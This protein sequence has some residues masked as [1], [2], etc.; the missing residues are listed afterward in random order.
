MK[1]ATLLERLARAG[2]GDQHVHSNDA[3]RLRDSILAN[4]R[5]V[6]ATRQGHAPAQ[7]D[8]GTPSPSEL[9]KDYPASIPR[10]QRTLGSCIQRYEPRLTAVRVRHLAHDSAADSDALGLRF[11]ISAELADGS[12]TPLLFTT[13]VDAHGRVDLAP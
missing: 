8:L 2:G 4:L 9:I 13:Q 11:Q 3:T 7:P 12:R 1:S 6:L 10:L 5:R